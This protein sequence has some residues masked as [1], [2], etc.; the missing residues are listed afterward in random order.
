[1]IAGSSAS[2]PEEASLFAKLDPL[3]IAAY[4]EQTR[5]WTA[6][7]RNT[8][9]LSMSGDFLLNRV[10]YLF[11]SAA[12]LTF[13]FLRF[14][15]RNIESTGKGPLQLHEAEK[16]SPG[17]YR[18]VATNVMSR[19]HYL[20]TLGSIFKLDVRSAITGIP[21]IIITAL[22][23]AFLG[24]ELYNSVHGGP[25]YGE[26]YATTGLIISKIMQVFP[27]F[28]V[29]VILFYSSE[30][31]WRSK[32][33]NF[34]HIDGATP[35]HH[36]AVFFSKFLSL[37]LIPV[38]LLSVSCL[39]GIVLQVIEG[40]PISL[41]LYGA[42][43]YLLG[44]PIVLIV[45]LAMAVQTCVPNK[46]GGLALASVITL[47][48]CTNLGRYI[49][50]F[51][52][53]FRYANT[54]SIPYS[55]M[56]GFGNYITAFHWQMVM[57][58]SLAVGMFIVTSSLKN[59]G[60]FQSLAKNRWLIAVTTTFILTGGY[61][62]YQTNIDHAY[63]TETDLNDWKEE[64]E[65]RYKRFQTARQPVVSGVVTSIDLYPSRQRY[66]V[67]GQYVLVNRTGKSIDSLLIYTAPNI[68]LTN[69]QIAGGTL[70]K[71][72]EEFGHYWYLLTKALDPGGK[73]TMKFSFSSHWSPFLGH[74]AFNSII[75]NGSF[76]RISN[77]YPRL[78][79]ESGNELTNSIERHKRGL[80][81]QDEL[82]K[83]ED[84]APDP[85]PHE[86]I[87]L[88]AI[89]STE[90]EQ[91]VIGSGDLVN[92]WSASSRN[93]FHYR[94]EKPIPFRFAFASARYK[95]ET[96]S[97]N[98]IPIEVYYHQGH[99]TNVMELI[100][101]IKTSLAYCEKNFGDYPHK[102][103]RFAEVSS[104]AEGF[105]ATAYPGTIYMKED[106]GFFTNVK[107]R[108][109]QELINKLAGHELSHQWWGSSS[110]VPEYKEGSWVLTE[111]LA[112][113]TELMLLKNAHGTQAV[114]ETVKMHLD[115]YLTA[116]SFSEEKPLYKTTFETP[117]IP[118]DK[119]LVV[120]YQ[121]EQLVG[122]DSINA[123]LNS[124][125]EHHAY[126]DTPPSSIDLINA[127]YKV[128]AASDHEKIDER[129][130]KIILYDS[131]IIENRSLRVSADQY[132]ITFT[133]EVTKYEENGFG[134]RVQL[135]ADELVDIGL[136]LEDE[137][138]V[139]KQFSARGGKIHGVMTVYRQPIT[140]T[141]DPLVKMIDLFPGDNTKPVDIQ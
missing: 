31:I 131:K 68:T 54:L 112:K 14:S 91:T 111:T 47:L 135:H 119:G 17:S 51:H 22:W 57:W 72:E 122:E 127:L 95:I 98:D 65:I 132:E 76:M 10:L 44:L 42:L 19:K 123:A 49:G 66:E 86:Y 115:L 136:L 139:V 62:F 77:Y 28:A 103:I 6:L 26:R 101:Q 113:Y 52:P 12:I 92:R 93:Y 45:V 97:F 58:S 89:V 70:I 29:L 48:L 108:E 121:L 140:I 50:I 21:L 78:G 138:R 102:A 18:P 118:Y 13:S 130:K 116:R 88:D 59:N 32:T 61:I 137:K 69:L 117:H 73:V 80:P 16:K 99:E 1:L 30:I 120:M 124:L 15:F 129:F 40:S 35:Q 90:E 43:F 4:F 87:H 104:F 106:G 100:N 96:N 33:A 56:N 128:S 84:P 74:T 105:A 53:L 134:Q 75:R 46:Y 83:I 24:I 71:S 5:Y 110:F 141:V 7:E 25:R 8:L 81:P 23:T 55:D 20:L 39:I 2:S 60:S 125:F 82:K 9:Q 38:L 3:G 79:Y 41:S 34:S 94:T 11:V 64:Y 133:A 109:Q 37:S 107:N 85:Y 114:I 67:Q 126:P 27:F 63:I 36:G